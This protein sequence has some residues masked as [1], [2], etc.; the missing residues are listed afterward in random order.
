MFLKNSHN[1]NKFKN[2]SSEIFKTTL[3]LLGSDRLVWSPSLTG[4]VSC[5]GIFYHLY[6]SNLVVWGK[7]LWRSFIPLRRS[8]HVWKILHRRLPTDEALSHRGFNIVSHCR[9]YYKHTES[10]DGIFLQCSFAQEMWRQLR[11]WF[12]RNLDFSGD[13][14][15]LF[16]NAMKENFSPQV[17]SLWMAGFFCSLLGFMAYEKFGNF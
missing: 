7:W 1:L 9:L 3:G 10:L 11:T 5:R 8:L 15:R 17:L 16:I 13:F 4:E 6:S 12:S 2:F 14:E